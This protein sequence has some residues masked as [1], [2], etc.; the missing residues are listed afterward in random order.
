MPRGAGKSAPL[1]PEA[2]R[3]TR[4]KTWVSGRASPD[5]L[6][7][8]SRAA[9]GPSGFGSVVTRV[10]AR[11]LLLCAQVLGRSGVRILPAEVFAK[12]V[13]HKDQT[14]VASVVEAD[15]REDA[16]VG[17]ELE[18]TARIFRLEVHGPTL[19][20]LH[21]ARFCQSSERQLIS[22]AAPPVA[23]VS[24][25]FLVGVGL[26]AV[27]AEESDL[28]GCEVRSS[29]DNRVTVDDPHDARGTRSRCEG[30]DCGRQSDY[31]W[32]H[33]A[34][35]GVVESMWPLSLSG[36]AVDACFIVMLAG[37]AVWESVRVLRRSGGG[38][39]RGAR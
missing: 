24:K 29:N 27:D 7:G 6:D 1:V 10:S 18:V 39:K 9:G 38:G 26:G 28:R 3:R 35:G 22:A 33:G 5:R 23:L 14:K 19:E 13:G 12:P 17:I 25:A 4:R 20:Q 16:V 2:R 31:K 30:D 11:C 34:V 8:R 37:V 32:S 36:L 21:R 15:V